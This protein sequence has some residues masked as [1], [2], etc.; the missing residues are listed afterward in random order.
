MDR[1]WLDAPMPALRVRRRDD[2]TAVEPNPAAVAWA[3]ERG[4]DLAAL[5]ALAQ[6]PDAPAG[7]LWTLGAARLSVVRVPLD[8]GELLWLQPQAAGESRAEQALKAAEFLDRALVLAGVS[9]WRIDLAAQRIHFNAVGFHVM[10]MVQDPL[11][12]PLHLM[13][14]TIH[15]DDRAAVVRAADE[16]LA[17]D[18]IVDVVARYR[19]AD[20]SWRTLLTRRVAVRDADGRAIGLAGV[21]LD[22]SAQMAERQRA[23][24]LKERALLVAEALGA[25]FWQREVD[26]AMLYWDE[27]LCRLYGRDPA[28]GPIPYAEWLRLC[29][30]EQDRAWVAERLQQAELRWEPMVELLF[31]A[32]DGPDGRPRWVQSW[33]RRALRDG[34]R[35]AYGMHMDVTDR[36]LAELGSRRE[37]QRAEIALQAA[38]IGVWERDRDR[39]LVY[40]NDAMYRQRGLDPADPRPLEE[41]ARECTD[42]DDYAAL[43]RLVAEHLHTGTPYRKEIRVRH[44]DGSWRRIVTEGR[45][46][47][48]PDGE[49]LGMAG[50]HLDVTERHE[51]EQLLLQ[52]QR[53]EQASRDKSA[54]MARMSH[55]LRTPMNAVLGFARLLRE[56][57]DE[58]PSVRQRDR[59]QR[60]VDAGER[61]MAMIDD[62]LELA[63]LEEEPAPPASTPQGLAEA[64]AA[65]VEAIAAGLPGRRAP[66]DLAALEGCR[67]MV[68]VDRRRLVQALEQL[69]RHA[70]AR[71]RPGERLPLRCELS[72]GQARLLVRLPGEALSA[73]QREWLFEPFTASGAQALP[74]AGDDRVGLAL[75]RRRLQLLGGDLAALAGADGATWLALTLPVAAVPGG[76]HVL[77]VE[78]NPV[79]LMLVR[80]L[81]ALRPAVLLRTAVDGEG[82]IRAA[83]ADPPDLLLLDL[84][85][86]DIDGREVMRRLR[87]EPAMAKCR[88]VAL[89]ADAMPDHVQAAL[90]AGFDGYWTKPIEFER[91][92]ADIDR[93]A[94]ERAAAPAAR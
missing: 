93:M 56:D 10:G 85:L 63:R 66:F 6:G 62:L 83:L 29:V 3:R 48:G 81:L 60:I 15:P 84:Q 50:V 17:G 51:A 59:L 4:I 75:A 47:Y 72:D 57:R 79:N 58:P 67:A 65:A 24:A 36:R 22:L 77:C 61:L 31:R 20:G 14:E 44:A 82:G 26:S 12:I 94:A 69:L 90:D 27:G 45:A 41:L 54:F 2:G 5:R 87:R 8:D 80:E 46:V 1:L 70:A 39:R 7:P 68:A 32:T 30:H 89:S 33:T 34:R 86:P 42:P 43:E 52:K 64:A 40:W 21:S 38:G 71:A 19:N 73:H 53:L 28:D 92:L 11:G 49:L 35:V 37:Q 23:E 13:R 88:I 74:A 76:L 78:D 25:G 91:F 18:R 16:A 9:V 55:E